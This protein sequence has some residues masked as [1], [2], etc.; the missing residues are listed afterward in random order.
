MLA[1]QRC[2]LG[3][4]CCWL[5][6][7]AVLS[8]AAAVP[9]SPAYF[10]LRSCAAAQ[11]Y[12]YCSRLLRRAALLLYG[13]LRLLLLLINPEYEFGQARMQSKRWWRSNSHILCLC[14]RL[15]FCP[16]VE[17]GEARKAE[18]CCAEKASCAGGGALLE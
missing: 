5:G 3:G 10:F 12:D 17:P 7:V 9:G 15:R 6:M 8:V 2:P 4:V 16:L 14:A 13:R 11:H 18:Q 1:Q